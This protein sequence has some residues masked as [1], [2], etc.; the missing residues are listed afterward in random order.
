MHLTS[1]DDVL[2]P[3]Y[4]MSRAGNGKESGRERIGRLGDDFSYPRVTKQDLTAEGPFGQ[5]IAKRCQS[6][7]FHPRRSQATNEVMFNISTYLFR[8]TSSR[9]KNVMVESYRSHRLPLFHGCIKWRRVSQPRGRSISRKGLVF[10][11]PIDS[12]RSSH[13]Q[14]IHCI[15]CIFALLSGGAQSDS[16]KLN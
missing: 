6:V 14:I 11:V 3:Y 5:V 10:C 4:R 13:R 15:A 8:Q 12:P 2:S 9:I 16:N 7:V 1:L